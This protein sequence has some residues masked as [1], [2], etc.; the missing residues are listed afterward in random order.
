[1]HSEQWYD[2][3]KGVKKEK[4]HL[5]LHVHF[6]YS[7]L[8][9]PNKVKKERYLMRHDNT[10]YTF[11]IKLTFTSTGEDKS[12]LQKQMSKLHILIAMAA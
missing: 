7:Y 1:M 8:I 4:F 6:N 2:L 9:E 3:I 12:K 5:T 10:T 11:L